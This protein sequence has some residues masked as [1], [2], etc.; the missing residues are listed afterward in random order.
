MVRPTRADVRIS[1]RRTRADQA[2]PL[3]PGGSPISTIR[4]RVLATSPSLEPDVREAFD[5]LI[6]FLHRALNDTEKRIGQLDARSGQAL[7]AA[8]IGCVSLEHSATQ[9]ISNNTWTTLAFDTENYD[10]GNLHLS[11]SNTRIT[12]PQG[13]RG[14]YSIGALIEFAGNSTG[15]RGTRFRLNGS[16][17][18]GSTARAT[19]IAT[20]PTTLSPTLR[21]LLKPVDYLNIQVFQTSGAALNVSSDVRFWAERI[22]TIE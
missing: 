20:D 7:M 4:Q 13:G 9:S 17:I 15:I 10:F 3:I 16:T 22:R 14:P 1:R 2:S 11:S 21:V 12:I 19:P 8:D 5:E 6:T 18:S